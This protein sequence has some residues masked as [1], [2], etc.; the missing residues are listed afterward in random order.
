[1]IATLDASEIPFGPGLAHGRRVQ[2]ATTEPV[3]RTLDR[4]T[5]PVYRRGAQAEERA[6]VN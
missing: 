4:E 3:H 6:E 5:M 2:A 1:M